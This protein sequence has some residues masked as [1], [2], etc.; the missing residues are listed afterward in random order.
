[1]RHHLNPPNHTDTLT[2]S[3][4]KKVTCTCADDVLSEARDLAKKHI[5]GAVLDFKIGWAGPSIMAESGIHQFSSFIETTYRQ[6]DTDDAELKAGPIAKQLFSV[7]YNYCP[8][9]G[10]ELSK[11]GEKS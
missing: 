10:R 1:M 7:T 9:C 4:K 3:G 5:D 8:I 11:S 2:V 6:I